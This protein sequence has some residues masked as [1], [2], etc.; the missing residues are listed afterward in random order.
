MTSKSGGGVSNVLTWDAENKLTRVVKITDASGGTPERATIYLGGDAEI[1]DQGTWT[2]C[3]HDDAKRVGNAGAAQTFFH[4]RD[5]L[6]C[7][8]LRLAASRF[9]ARR[10]ASRGQG[11]HE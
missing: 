2:K 3:V 8:C 6:K 4:H 9:T 10:I 1:D 5:H 11:D 7:H